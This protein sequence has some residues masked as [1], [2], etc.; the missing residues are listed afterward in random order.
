MRKLLFVVVIPL[1]I[2]CNKKEATHNFSSGKFE[3]AIKN[4]NSSDL[5]SELKKLMAGLK[6]KEPSEG[7]YCGHNATFETLKQR[8]E[9]FAPNCEMKIICICC[10]YSYPAKSDILL[11][12]NENGTEYEHRLLI[13]TP[14]EQELGQ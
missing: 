8:V 3:Q 5:M 9:T 13:S 11:K 1:L 12:Y 14:E 10:Y 7:D 2:S 4:N 6:G